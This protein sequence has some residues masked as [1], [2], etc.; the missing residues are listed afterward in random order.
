MDNDE[1]GADG[2]WGFG[3]GGAVGSALATISPTIANTRDPDYLVTGG[4]G[5]CGTQRGME[6]VMNPALPSR[7]FV[8]SNS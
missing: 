5:G 4:G 6:T 8:T 2:R 3:I 7:R 1:G